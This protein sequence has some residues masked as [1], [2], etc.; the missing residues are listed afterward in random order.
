MVLSVEGDDMCPTTRTPTIKPLKE[1][2]NRR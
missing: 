2:L 1:A